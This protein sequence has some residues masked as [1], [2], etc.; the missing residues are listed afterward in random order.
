L[1]RDL[2]ERAQAG[3]ETA[4]ASLAMSVGDRLH[5]TAQ[6]ILHDS[7]RADDVAQDAMIEVWRRLPTLREAE[8]FEAWA[9]RIL[10]RGAFAE[11]R[12]QSRW[13]LRGLLGRAFRTV[14]PDPADRVADRDQLDFALDR[15]PIG[16]RAVVVLKYFADLSNAQIAEAVGIPEGTVR[17]RLHYA[18]GAM[19]ATLVADARPSVDAVTP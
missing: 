14:E 3:D 16:H 6:H 13:S 12:R 11:A 9:Y 7:P 17:S 19:R 18:I 10:V 15:L 8:C 5:A 1:D 2:V 4:F